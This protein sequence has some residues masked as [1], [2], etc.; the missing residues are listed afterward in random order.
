MNQLASVPTSCLPALVAAA[1]ARPLSLPRVFPRRSGT[2]ARA[3]PMRARPRNSSTGLR[4]RASRRSRQSRACMSPP[5]SNLH[6][7]VGLRDRALI[8]LM[9]YSFA[10]SARL[11][12][13]KVRSNPTLERVGRHGERQYERERRIIQA[14]SA[15]AFIP[16]RGAIVLVVDQQGDAADILGDAD[17]AMRGAYEESAA[18]A[19]ALHRVIDR[20]PAEAEHGRVVTRQALLRERRRPRIFVRRGAQRCLLLRRSYSWPLLP[21]VVEEC[22][23]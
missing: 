12:G 11:L 1:G 8:G 7:A 23:P 10:A 18:E 4:R 5:T 2:R 20:E 17:A 3:A 15:V 13:A 22:R 16:A 19:P 14:E 9:L 6:R 21:H